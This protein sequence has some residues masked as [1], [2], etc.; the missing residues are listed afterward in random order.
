ME[1]FKPM[2]RRLERQILQRLDKLE[3]LLEQRMDTHEQQITQDRQELNRAAVV[4][5]LPANAALGALI[6]LRGDQTGALY[7]GNGPNRPVTKLL[8]V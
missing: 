2:D 5:V 4:D 8:P 3:S 7:L 6:R 1:Q